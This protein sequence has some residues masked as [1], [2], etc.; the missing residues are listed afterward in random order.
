MMEDMT[1]PEIRAAMDDGCDTVIVAFGATHQH[2]PHLPLGTDAVLGE[3][4]ARRVAARLGALVA[5][6]VPLGCSRPHMGYAGTLSLRPETFGAIVADVV[7]SLAETGFRRCVLLP[8]H[9]GNLVALAA[10]V[11]RLPE[12]ADFEVV[13]LTD[14]ELLM[15]LTLLGQEELGVPLSAGGLHAGEWETS[16]LLA[17]RPDLVRLDRLEAGYTGD[18]QLALDA[19]SESGVQSVALNG[20]L[21]DPSRACVE[22]GERYWACAEQVAL[23]AVEE[24]PRH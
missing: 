8:S 7:A 14:A 19:L 20:V 9:A 11:A 17:A 16:M 13:A 5:P 21:G 6:T 22:H 1:W 24:G 4:L 10:A 18:A 15:R 23:D 12:R 2:G 3:H